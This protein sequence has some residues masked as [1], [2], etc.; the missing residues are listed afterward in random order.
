MVLRGWF[1]RS[2]RNASQ[3]DEADAASAPDDDAP[4][5]IGRWLREQRL[6]SGFTLEQAA[7][8]TRISFGYLDA[9]E[10]DRFDVLPA[11]VYVRGFVR[12][13]A[14]FLGIDPE[15]AIERLPEDLPQPPGLEPLPGLRLREGVGVLPAVSRR[16]VVLAVLAAIVLVAAL[17]F[18][19]PN[20]GFGLGG[21]G[22]GETV[23]TPTAEAT[24]TPLAE[25]MPDLSGLAQAEAEQRVSELGAEV[26]VIEVESGQAP[27]GHVFAQTP[28]AGEVLEADQAVTLVVAK[29]PSAGGE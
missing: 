16:W 8:E 24:A 9:I 2:A 23:A 1:G 11:P 26:V 17:V 15:D 27:P 10:A 4:R 7:E 20:V 28:A 14:R 25:Q 19:V 3:D 21:D 13:Y 6:Q 5:T 12:L 22:E 18:G 29:E